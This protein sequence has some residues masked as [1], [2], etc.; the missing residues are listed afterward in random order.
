MLLFKLIVLRGPQRKI[1]DIVM[2]C[3][4]DT[5]SYFNCVFKQKYGMTPKSFQKQIVQEQVQ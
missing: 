2:D 5:R 4:F 1:K 3:G